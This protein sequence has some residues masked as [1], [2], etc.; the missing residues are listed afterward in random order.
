MT[1]PAKNTPAAT[2]APSAAVVPAPA[3]SKRDQLIALLSRDEGAT[4]DEMV[5]ALGWLR[6]TTRAA[7]TGL[8]KKGIS[9]DRV[10]VDGASRYRIVGGAA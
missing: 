9:V 8:K 3:P 10:K 6:H 4:L 2:A 5:T 7:L 1:R